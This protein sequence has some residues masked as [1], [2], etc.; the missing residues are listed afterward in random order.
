MAVVRSEIVSLKLSS[1]GDYV[2]QATYLDNLAI[3]LRPVAIKVSIHA[4][5]IMEMHERI[6]VQQGSKTGQSLPSLPATPEFHRLRTGVPT[7]CKPP[8]VGTFHG[9][10]P[11][12]LSLF[13][14]QVAA[15]FLLLLERASNKNWH[16][17]LSPSPAINMTRWVH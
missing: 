6:G 13:A 16:L 11:F 4:Q 1:T 3:A 9:T 5:V 12:Q 17:G 8:K 7:R 14:P 2:R 15:F 10:L